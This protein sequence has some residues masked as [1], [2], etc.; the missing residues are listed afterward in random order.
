[1]SGMFYGATNFNQSIGSWN[2]SQVTDMSDTFEAAFDFNQ[3]IG[4]W[5]TSS[6]TD[7]SSMFVSASDF[8]QN[9][10]SWDTSSVTNMENMFTFAL[11]DNN[12]SNWDVSSLE[13]GSEGSAYDMFRGGEISTSNYDAL[14]C[15]WSDTSNMESSL[16]SDVRLGVPGV[17]YTEQGCRDILTNKGWTINDAGQK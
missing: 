11:Y 14:L 3:D 1:M 2:T 4:S 9:L 6:V 13:G 7:M 16:N 15:G 17:Q 12:V 8:N 5:N 10:N